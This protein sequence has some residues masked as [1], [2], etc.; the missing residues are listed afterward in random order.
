MKTF[1]I[2]TCTYNAGNVLR[3]TLRSVSQ[4]GYTSV[5]HIIVDGA[6]GDDTVGIALE[7]QKESMGSGHE[8]MVKSERD[9][10]LYD[11]M[12]KGI[13][14]A[15]GTYIAFLN[16]GDTLPQPDTLERI[17]QVAEQARAGVI[18]GDTDIVDDE[19]HF[20]RHRRLT[21][22]DNLTW[23]SFKQGMLVCHQAF[24]A[25]TTLAKETRYN[26]E[27]Y[28]YS[29]DVDWCIRVMKLAEQRHMPLARV[30]GVI[31]NYLEGGMT[32]ENHRASLAER[33]KIMCQHYGVATTLAMHA[34]FLVRRK[35]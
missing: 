17:A 9:K 34:W 20:V 4:Q 11:A 33:F 8:V 6:S 32:T 7:Y 23:R 10:G 30:Q 16:A 3:R 24:Y 21:P 27:E 2:I 26:N 19:G 1:S 29:A 14:M 28:K 22:P 31:A 12:N 15:S 13:D 18:Y 5:E 35:N 25:N